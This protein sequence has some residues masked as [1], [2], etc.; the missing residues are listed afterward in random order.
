MTLPGDQPRPAALQG[1]QGHGA[2][3]R[4]S[5]TRSTARRCSPRAVTW[6]AS[7]PTRSCLRASPASATRTCTRSRAPDLTTAKKWAGEGRHQGRQDGQYYTSNTGSAPLVAQIVQFNLKQIGLNVNSH[8]FARA[9]QIDK[10]GTRGEPFDITSEGWIADYADP[11][12][13]INVLLSGDNLHASNNNNVAY[14]NNPTYNAQMRSASL[15]SGVARYNGVRQ[16]RRQHDVE[17]PAVGCPQQLQRPHPAL[18]ACRL[19]HRTTRSTA[20]I[21]RLSA[22]S[23]RRTREK[24]AN[25]AAGAWAARRLFIVGQ[26]RAARRRCAAAARCVPSRGTPSTSTS[27]PPTMKSVCTVETLTPSLGAAL[28]GLGVGAAVGDVA[29][30]VLVEERVEERHV[31]SCRSRDVPSTSATSP[32]YAA[33]S[34][35][36]SCASIDVAALLCAYLDDAARLEAHLEAAA[37]CGRR[38]R[39]A[40]SSGRRLPSAAGPA[41]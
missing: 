2:A 29:G 3:R 5:T 11:Y 8:L 19:L 34:S 25:Q 7:A 1:R 4:R 17:Q 6:P 18:E 26:S 39:A 23:N 41:S 22:S 14:F 36:A 20:S 30:R 27:G 9:V 16:P 28:D 40:A 32:R 24:V 37:R 13:F 10:E 38:A 15:L 31:P 35:V 12:D 21:W 33:A